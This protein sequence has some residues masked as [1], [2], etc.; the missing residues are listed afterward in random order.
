MNDVRKKVAKSLIFLL[1]LG[2]IIA[3]LCIFVFVPVHIT[4]AYSSFYMEAKNSLDVTLIG[5]STVMFDYIP[6]LAY[7]EGGVTSHIIGSQ[8]SHPEVI[9]IAIEEVYRTQGAS[10]QVV[11]I[12]LTGLTYQTHDQ[13]E[14]L[15]RNY[16]DSMPESEF[17]KEL[18]N[19]YSYLKNSGNG[20]FELFKYHN[21]F[22]NYELF[23][24]ASGE[25]KKLKGHKPMGGITKINA[26]NI[27][28]N[29]TL[30]LPKDGQ[31]YLKEI[32]DVA[33][34]Y[35]SM[36]FLFGRMPRFV[37]SHNV[38]DC[39][40]LR[41]AKP[42]IESYGYQY[43]DFCEYVY[44]IG[45]D[46][47]KHQRDEEHLNIQGASIF[48]PYFINYLKNNYSLTPVEKSSDVMKDF[49]NCY[50]FYKKKYL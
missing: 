12:D 21:N 29:K 46:P 38:N 8:P 11:F 49:N 2:A 17:K 15:V 44:D 1:I 31:D 24:E 19:R 48:T 14:S 50:E 18:A 23:I 41:S 13:Q 9:K 43:V 4:N 6:A 36:Q 33:K 32:L 22:R 34:K 30:P 37:A 39:Y 40:T 26:V 42:V 7:H 10:S 47:N 28:P 16:Y 20:G 25:Q 5:N 45:L 3:L 27:D 35:P